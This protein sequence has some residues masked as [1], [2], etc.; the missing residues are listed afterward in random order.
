M[1]RHTNDDRGRRSARWVAGAV[2]LALGA[3]LAGCDTDGLIDL[4]DPDL[5]TLPVVVDPNNVDAVRNGA[6]FEFA[7]AMTGVAT[8]NSTPGLVG[9]SGLL[10][11]E[12]WYASSFDS[13]KRIDRRD[14][15]DSNV[16]VQTVYSW[17]HRARNLA[18][19]AAALMEAA[20]PDSPER[21][22]LLSLSGYTFVLFA[23]NWCSHVP[24]SRSPIGG[25]IEYRPAIGHQAMLDSAVTKFDAAIGLAQGAGAEGAAF[26]ALARLG[27]ARA[28]QDMGRL[29]EAAA[30]A[31]QIPPGFEYDVE[32]SSN[33]AGQGNGLWYNVNAESRTSAAS[34]EGVNGI[35]FFDRGNGNNVIDPRVQVDSFGTGLGETVPHYGQLRY[36]DQGA[37]IP[38]ASW[39]E[40]QLI[41]AEAD[42]AGGTTAG[43]GAAGN[44]L[45]ILN[46]L[47]AD[48]GLAALTDPGNAPDRVLMLYEERAFW[49][50]LTAHR[51][52]DLRRLLRIGDYA[53][54]FTEDGLFPI[55]PTIFNANRGD[56]VAFPIPIQE[57]NNPEYDE[58]GCDP[59]IP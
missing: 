40:A 41:I 58:T 45:A 13:M 28:L 1:R 33:S 53:G 56:D 54:M 35:R 48:A 10:A 32:Y 5:I 50:W 24:F 31:M 59:S 37:D 20:Q 12:F 29:D 34:G 44:W 3:A 39:T 2:A 42:L 47:R 22:R 38:L 51:V 11:D 52:G 4:D 16:Q 9:I 17:L 23:E 43:S 7:Q 55:G 25:Q 57:L 36:E 30:E 19:E 46:D 8:N 49:L 15:F 6:L 18:D 21:A 26:L 14:I 27:K